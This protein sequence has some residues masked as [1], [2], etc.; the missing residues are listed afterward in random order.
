M[1]KT[2]ILSLLL[3]TPIVLL[4]LGSCSRTGPQEEEA[5]PSVQLTQ[6]PAGADYCV[7]C[8]D[9]CI[10]GYDYNYSYQAYQVILVKGNCN[11]ETSEGKW[12]GVTVG[13][14]E[15][16]S[17]FVGGPGSGSIGD[18]PGHAQALWNFNCNG[19]SGNL[20]ISVNNNWD[21]WINYVT[22]V[23]Q[24]PV[25]PNPLGIAG[26]PE[27]WDIRIDPAVDPG[28]VGIF[29][30]GVAQAQALIKIRITETKNGGLIVEM[31]GTGLHTY[32]LD[33]SDLPN[34]DYTFD[35]EF[36]PGFH[37]LYPMQK[38]NPNP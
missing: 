5:S 33:L 24:Q 2:K 1:R 16:F 17:S 32:D 12:H 8:A 27:G 11:C 13:P 15:V 18:L 6:N 28:H 14:S 31:P 25:P 37:L 30:D 9:G 20:G 19:S 3:L 35:L 38:V 10:L 4:L 23:L 21:L 29:L 36:Q 26:W 22:G 34:G 7:E